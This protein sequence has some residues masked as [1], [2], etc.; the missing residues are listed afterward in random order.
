M[1]CLH[2]YMY[3]LGVTC[4]H[5]CIYRGVA[6][7]FRVVRYR[8]CRQRQHCREVALC[9]GVWGHAPENFEI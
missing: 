4:V 6:T 2:I 7:S 5:A 8:L 1:P 3:M 9:R